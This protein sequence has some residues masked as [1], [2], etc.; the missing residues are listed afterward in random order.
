MDRDEPRD[1]PDDVDALARRFLD[2]W[3]EQ[4]ALLATDPRLAELSGAWLTLWQ[5]G[6]GMAMQAAAGEGGG[7]ARQADAGRNS[8]AGRAERPAAAAAASGDGQPDPA[9]LARR[10]AE[11]EARI[12]ALESALA[13]S[14]RAGSARKPRAASRRSRSG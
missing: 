9:E 2:L 12:A 5:R 4:A 10:L 11:C 13:E 7:N 14:G 3:Q 8:A 1:R 6:A